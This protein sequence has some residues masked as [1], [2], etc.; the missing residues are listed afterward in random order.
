MDGE[1]SPYRVDLHGDQ[2]AVLDEKGEVVCVCGTENNAHH[3]E[4]LLRRAYQRGYK[5]GYRTAKRG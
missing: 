2:Y 3:Y 4:V 5:A 1:E